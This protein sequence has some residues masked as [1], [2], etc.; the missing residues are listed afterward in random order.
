MKFPWSWWFS[1]IRAGLEQGLSGREIL[2]MARDMGAEIRNETFWQYYNEVRQSVD[3]EL[4]TKR[5]PDDRLL[6][7]WAFPRTT[8]NIPSR[9]Q[10]VV[11]VEGYDEK[12][13]RIKITFGIYKDYRVSKSEVRR[14]A[15]E[16]AQIEYEFTKI[17]RVRIIRA[18]RRA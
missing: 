15:I 7:D 9:Y 2:R 4:Y 16:H 10:F 8:V 12:G 17:T 5:I 6:P 14:E 13:R 1:F 3:F 11:E 18:R